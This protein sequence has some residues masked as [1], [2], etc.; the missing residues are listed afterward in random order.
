MKLWPRHHARFGL[1]CLGLLSCQVLAGPDD[2]NRPVMDG[3]AGPA[4]RGPVKA[5]ARFVPVSERLGLNRVQV[6][7][8]MLPAFDASDLL[9]EDEARWLNGDRTMRTGIVMPL[10]AAEAEGA[11]LDDGKGGLLWVADVG[12]ESALGLR[13]HLTEMN[14]P[15]FATLS[16]QS[17]ADR[18]VLSGPLSGKGDLGSGEVWTES[19]RGGAARIEYHLPA[20]ALEAI[21]AVGG[22]IANPGLP[23]RVA[24]VLHMYVI[25]GEAQGQRGETE[26]CHV[27]IDC[28][29]AW[30][31]AKAST[32]RINFI[33]NGGG[34]LC[35][36][37]LLTASRAT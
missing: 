22:D 8:V 18:Q 26:P 37:E 28:V 2:G 16:A 31:V 15:P 7:Q 10:N 27:D 33:K 5:E 17:L 30:N 11:W 19:L 12:S 3:V 25:P 24:D 36:G 35:T 14:L 21:K 29:A 6:P 20:Q 4:A 23:F 13:I 34:F 9:A 1:L 32:G